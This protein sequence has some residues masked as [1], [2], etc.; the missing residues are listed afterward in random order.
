MNPNIEALQDGTWVIKNDTHI[1]KWVKEH[2]TLACDPALFR[3]MRKWLTDPHIQTVWDI[4]ANIGDHTFFYLSLGKQVV[5]V[6]PNHLAFECLAHN[7]P[8]AILL[9]NAASD[10]T[11][12]LR[13]T[14]LENVGA[15]RITGD[16][17]IEVEAIR[18][19]DAPVP[20]PDF[21]KIDVEGF[22]VFALQ[23][24]RQTLSHSLPLVFVEVNKS[25][26]AAN[27]HNVDDILKILQDAGYN[28]FTEYPRGI[29]WESE[30]FDILAKP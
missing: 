21:V 10:E 18:M 26:L 27:G 8:Q 14:A 24:M 20:P 15:S 6:E 11:G 3:I 13:F 1:S 28:E 4:G 25:A 2:G 16:G 5:S 7:C 9:N 17:N 22:E 19:D 29:S 12:T 30:Q 23:G